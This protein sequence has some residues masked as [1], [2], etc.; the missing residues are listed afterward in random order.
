MYHHIPICLSV[1]SVL[2][3][4]CT[5]RNLDICEFIEVRNRI[6]C[7]AGQVNRADCSSRGCCWDASA[8]PNCYMGNVYGRNLL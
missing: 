8:G 1:I 7:G 4:N 2:S 5:D 3:Y 6:Q